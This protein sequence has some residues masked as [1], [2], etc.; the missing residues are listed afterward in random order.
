MDDDLVAK[1]FDKIDK[2][3]EILNCMKKVEPTKNNEIVLAKNPFQLKDQE[4]QLSH[5]EFGRLCI[6]RDPVNGYKKCQDL[7]KRYYKKY[8]PYEDYKLFYP[9]ENFKIFHSIG[10]GKTSKLINIGRI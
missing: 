6:K 4:S 10:K 8:D 7:C 2:I 5:E 1:I 3:D 9:Y